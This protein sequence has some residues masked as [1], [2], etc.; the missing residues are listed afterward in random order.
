VSAI[1]SEVGALKT[2]GQPGQSPRYQKMLHRPGR[3]VVSF[4]G[5]PLEKVIILNLQVFPYVLPVGRSSSSFL[6]LYGHTGKV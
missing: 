1:L 6:P 3:D 4:G 5:E 2:V